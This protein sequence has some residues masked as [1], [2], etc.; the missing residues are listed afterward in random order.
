[1]ASLMN[2]ARTLWDVQQTVSN[3]LGMDLRRASF[4]IRCA[5]LAVDASIALLIKVLTDT[6]VVSDANLNTAVQAVR[7]MNIEPLPTQPPVVPED[8]SVIPP[9]PPITGV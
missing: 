8:G 2:Y 3:K 6:G 1:M 4:E 9:P 7:A 5:V